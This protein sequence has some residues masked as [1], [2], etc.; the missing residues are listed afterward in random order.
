MCSN[1]SEPQVLDF[2]GGEGVM[3]V[4]GFQIMSVNTF[5]SR[6]SVPKI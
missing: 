4:I 6:R 3:A 2:E 5:S 1:N